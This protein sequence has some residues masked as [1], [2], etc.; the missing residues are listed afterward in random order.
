M[1][2]S[3]MM[4]PRKMNFTIGLI[5][6]FSLLL[7]S[8]LCRIFHFFG[9]GEAFSFEMILIFVACW[10]LTVCSFSSWP[11]SSHCWKWQSTL[12]PQL[13][14][15]LH[16]ILPWWYSFLEPSALI[17]SN[18]WMLACT[19]RIMVWSLWPASRTSCSTSRMT[20]IASCCSLRTISS[21]FFAGPSVYTLIEGLPYS[22]T[23]T[24]VHSAFLQDWAPRTSCWS[25][26]QCFLKW[27]LTLPAAHDR[28]C[29]DIFQS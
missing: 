16:F 8:E 26:E 18:S 29:A 12:T 27:S 25:S 11:W 2:L 20:L 21:S 1:N 17:Q 22:S 4:T 5:E 14:H 13:L 6:T 3:W 24:P 28:P 7:I 10:D 15:Y 23:Y 9:C 19:A